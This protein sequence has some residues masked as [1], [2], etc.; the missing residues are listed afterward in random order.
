MYR[1]GD[2][3]LDATAKV[4]MKQ[5]QPVALAR[6]AVETLLV[7]VE[8]AGQVSRPVIEYP[9]PLGSGPFSVSPDGRYLLCVRVEPSNSDLMRVEPFG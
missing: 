6:K 3:S 8:S 9:E 5:G 4:L 2:L 1:F 7:L